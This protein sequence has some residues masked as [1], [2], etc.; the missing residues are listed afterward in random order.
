MSE[1][2]K[3]PEDKPRIPQSFFP[4][5]AK[6]W[7]EAH[8]IARLIRMK[9]AEIQ[10]AAII[11]VGKT[12]EVIELLKQLYVVLPKTD[13]T[14]FGISPLAPNLV[15]ESLMEFIFKAESKERNFSRRIKLGRF[16]D[17]SQSFDFDKAVDRALGW[18]FKLEKQDVNEIV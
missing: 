5:K 10:S 3:K 2:E 6:S 12:D 4:D 8:K 13:G 7:K 11:L 15:V 1:V 9:V 18:A 17:L 16:L 14:L